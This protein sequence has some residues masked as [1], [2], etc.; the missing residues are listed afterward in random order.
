MDILSG[1]TIPFKKIFE[2]Q[3][4]L[5]LILSE[6]LSIQAATDAYLQEI[7]MSRNAILGK[8]IF[9]VFPDKTE[10]SAVD[11]PGNLKISLLQVLS[12]RKAHH[13]GI[14]H[15]NI[16]DPE[17]PGSFLERYWSITNTPLLNEQG[18]ISCII[19]ETANVTDTVISERVLRESQHREQIARAFAAQQE[20]RVY[21]FFEQAPIAIAVLEGP[22][23]VIEQAN[24][25]VCAIWGRKQTDVLGK[26]LFEALP[27]IKGQ[28]LEELLAG[29][30]ETGNP[31][32]GYEL[33]V[34]L[35]R[36]GR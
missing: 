25:A 2:S 16:P 24:P 20:D 18:E 10:K 34:V 26:P 7:N 19:H 36:A 17:N 21:S 11:A 9:D 29:V 15:Y 1:D 8:Y 12:S 5:I 23:Y 32:E 33:P 30:L 14:S 22:E 4:G 27:E 31:Y 35:N 6:E 13:M 3:P 28:G